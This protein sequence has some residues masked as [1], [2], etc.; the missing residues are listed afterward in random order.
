MAELEELKKIVRLL[1]I[2]LSLS[3]EYAH[4]LTEEEQTR[5]YGKVLQSKSE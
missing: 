3:G 4:Q 1:E 2:S 5:V